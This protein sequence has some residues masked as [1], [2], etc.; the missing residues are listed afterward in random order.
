MRFDNR[1][2][3]AVTLGCRL[4]QADTAL[5]FSRLTTAGFEIIQNLKIHTPDVIII[6]TCTVTCNAA[7]KSRQ[8]ARQLKR[9]YPSSCMVVT[10]CDCNKAIDAWKAEEIVDIVMANNGKKDIIAHLTQWFNNKSNTNLQDNKVT[11]QAITPTADVFHEDTFAS[12]PFRQ[13]AFLKIQEGCNSFCTYCIVPFVRGPERSRAYEEVINEAKNLINQNYKEIIITGVNI[14]TYND[15]SHKITDLL[16]EIASLPG[17]FRIRLSSMEP[18]EENLALIDLISEYK[19]ICPFLHIPVQSGSN[20][21]LD[22]MGRKYNSQSF[23]DFINYARTKI[24]NIHLGTDIISGFPGET[25]QLFEETCNFL[26]N[27][28]FANI[29]SFRFSPREG[30]PAADFKNQVPHR[31]IKNRAEIIQKIANE[32]KSKFIYSQLGEELNILVEKKDFDSNI[33]SGW[34]ENYIKTKFPD[35]NLMIGTFKKLVLGKKHLS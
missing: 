33:C 13:R 2:V 14:S 24:P 28:S 7:S 16:Q 32:S 20:K 18:H 1:K 11:I 26:K 30:T 23:L 35:E 22:K 31:I 25:D 8:A 29:H 34:T 3:Y 5:L 17:E 21:I 10:G 27:A 19:K 4:N 6:N 15:S 9:K 12:F